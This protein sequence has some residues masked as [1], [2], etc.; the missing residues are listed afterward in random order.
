MG[1]LEKIKWLVNNQ[2]PCTKCIQSSSCCGCLNYYD[3]K[4]KFD[5]ATKKEAYNVITVISLK[6]GLEKYKAT[7][8]E[9]VKK[10]LIFK[11]RDLSPSFFIIFCPKSYE[12]SYRHPR[13]GFSY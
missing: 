6:K 4:A 5:D 9:E 10:H 8:S 2:I 12:T 7:I 3:W 13:R 1:K 11:R